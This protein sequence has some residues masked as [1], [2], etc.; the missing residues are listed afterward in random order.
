M[1][2]D[3]GLESRLPFTFERQEGVAAVSDLRQGF[4]QQKIV[5]PHV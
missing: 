2:R 4:L 3:H 1:S 5:Q